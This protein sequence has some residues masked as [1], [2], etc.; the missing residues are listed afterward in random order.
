MCSSNF[1]RN[2]V[3]YKPFAYTLYVSNIKN[4]MNQTNK[5]KNKRKKEYIWSRWEFI[6]F[7]ATCFDLNILPTYK[8]FNLKLFKIKKWNDDNR[9]YILHTS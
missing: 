8:F 4:E 1:F 7:A 6:F 5:L 9:K 3:T 2:K